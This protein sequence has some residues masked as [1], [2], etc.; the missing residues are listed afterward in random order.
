MS[1]SIDNENVVSNTNGTE[2]GEFTPSTNSFTFFEEGND[3]FKGPIAAFLKRVG[4]LVTTWS[5][6]GEAPESRNKADIPPRPKMNPKSGIKTPGLVRWME[7]YALDEFKQ[8]FGI[9]GRGTVPIVEDGKVVGHKETWI[10]RCKT[11]MSEKAN[12]PF[13]MDPNLYD[14]NAE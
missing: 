3:R 6:E 5:V 8:T 1:Y 10:G 7:K 9:T 4:H 2:L 12:L 13:G 14:I 11:C